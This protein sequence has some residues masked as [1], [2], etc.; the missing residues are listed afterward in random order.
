MAKTIAD[1]PNNAWSKTGTYSFGE[2]EALD[3]ARNAVH[4]GYHHLRD[5][6][7]VLSRVIGAPVEI[8][9]DGDV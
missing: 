3:M 6:Q 9:E 4:E 1:V 2:R 8:E 5:V 7:S